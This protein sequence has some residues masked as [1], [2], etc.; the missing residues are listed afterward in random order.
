MSLEEIFAFHTQE[1]GPVRFAE[2]FGGWV[3]TRY[4]DVDRVLTEHEV[5]SSDELR[6][7]SRPV[8]H[9]SNPM[10]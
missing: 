10:L 4:A 7:S 9:G 8:P 3:V 2:P 1:V 6:Y 5:F